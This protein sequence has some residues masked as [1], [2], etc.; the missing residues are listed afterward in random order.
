M[1]IVQEHKEN[2]EN[3]LGPFFHG[4][5]TLEPHSQKKPIKLTDAT[6]WFVKDGKEASLLVSAGRKKYNIPIPTFPKPFTGQH[7]FTLN[8][9]RYGM[10]RLHT[11]EGLPQSEF[12]KFCK[13]LSQSPD[14][15]GYLPKLDGTLPPVTPKK[16]S[17]LGKHQNEGRL[18]LET[19][20]ET[21]AFPLGQ[22]PKHDGSFPPVTPKK[23]SP[24]SNKKAESHLYPETPKNSIL[25][26]FVPK[27]TLSSRV[28]SFINKRK[29]ETYSLRPPGLLTPPDET[30]KTWTP[31][32]FYGIKNNYATNL[33]GSPS[34]VDGIKNAGQTCYMAATIQM[35]YFSPFKAKLHNAARRTPDTQICYA[36]SE[37]FRKRDERKL[38]SV[39]AL[40]RRL[41]A[42]SPRF[43][44]DHQED[45]QEFLLELFS[46]LK[47]EA[48]GVGLA[49]CPVDSTFYWLAERTTRCKTC[50]KTSISSETYA[51]LPL[52]LLEQ[53]REYHLHTL[54]K[55]FFKHEQVTLDCGTCHATLADSFYRIRTLPPVMVVHVKRFGVVED[56]KIQKRNDIVEI[57]LCVS[58]DAYGRDDKGFRDGDVDALLSVKGQQDHRSTGDAL[59]HASPVKNSVHTN[60][61]ALERSGRYFLQSIISHL[62]S[63]PMSGHYVTDVYDRTKS[64]WTC[65]DDTA[66]TEGLTSVEKRRERSAYLLAYIH[67]SACM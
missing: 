21:T 63:E 3:R 32:N 5:L 2:E 35:L 30:R 14:P 44:H 25:S 7:S 17:P 12:Y 54:I 65:F 33:D 28:D 60:E 26:G 38:V 45:A 49:A 16:S 62:G 8:V 39:A 42:V 43:A 56:M 11:P 9:K 15:L 57:P 50:G 6:V 4:H 53:G 24:L 46:E 64:S 29:Q 48:M 52:D 66:V 67:E 19:P 23:P 10:V 18:Y 20:K 61:N 31:S 36:L 51:T 13:T 58:F 47:R 41:G 40:K 55:E 27:N 1:D 34:K 37:I 59:L 22:L